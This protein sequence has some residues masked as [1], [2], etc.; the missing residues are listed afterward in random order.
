[1]HFFQNYNAESSESALEK[2][3]DLI[4]SHGLPCLL[5][6]LCHLKRSWIIISYT[7]PALVL[8][9]RG[10][11][12]LRCVIKNVSMLGDASHP[13]RDVLIEDPTPQ[14]QFVRHCLERMY[15][16]A[17]L[18]INGAPDLGESSEATETTTLENWNEKGAWLVKA[19]FGAWRGARSFRP[20]KL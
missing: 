10:A 2:P 1:M 11:T 13:Q 15:L 19:R 17:I 9:L 16:F 20:K 12:F 3:R 18:E 6:G 8:S 14:K 7:A 5:M 4:T